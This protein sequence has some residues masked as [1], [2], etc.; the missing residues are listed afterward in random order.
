MFGYCEC[1]TCTCGA[2]K[3]KFANN[4]NPFKMRYQ[5]GMHSV[6]TKDF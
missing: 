3:C 6:Y 2:C 5:N 4:P 1:Y